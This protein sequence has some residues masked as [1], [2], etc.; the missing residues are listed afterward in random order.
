MLTNLPKLIAKVT[1]ISNPIPILF[2][3]K[4]NPTIPIPI[5]IKIEFSNK[6]ET[7]P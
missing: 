1:L 7:I 2:H 5:K 3:A 4:S 6:L